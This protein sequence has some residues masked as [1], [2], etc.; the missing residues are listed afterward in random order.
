MTSTETATNNTTTNDT[1][2]TCTQ[3]NN[4]IRY[5]ARTRQWVGMGDTNPTCGA[6]TMPFFPHIPTETNT[7]I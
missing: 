6:Y 2:T 5:Y 3:C 1:E 7:T 4:T